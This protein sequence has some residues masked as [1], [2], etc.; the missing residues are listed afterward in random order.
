VVHAYRIHTLIS[1]CVFSIHGKFG[2]D[3]IDTSTRGI[4]VVNFVSN[5]ETVRVKIYTIENADKILNVCLRTDFS[6]IMLK[7]SC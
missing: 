2:M 7:K 3:C 6:V 5:K 4:M 1:M